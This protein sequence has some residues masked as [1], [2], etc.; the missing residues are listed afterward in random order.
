MFFLPDA[1]PYLRNHR[2]MHLLSSYPFSFMC[3]AFLHAKYQDTSFGG[4]KCGPMPVRIRLFSSTRKLLVL[5]PHT[6]LSMCKALSCNYRFVH[7]KNIRY[8]GTLSKMLAG[9]C[10]LAVSLQYFL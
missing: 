9:L 3:L 1:C 5:V 2:D 10:Y 4:G 6:A 8:L 7:D